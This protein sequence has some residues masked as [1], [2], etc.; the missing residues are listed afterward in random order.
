MK[1]TPYLNFS[2][3]GFGQDLAHASDKDQANLFNGISSEWKVAMGYE[4]G[5]MQMCYLS[6]YLSAEARK[7]IIKLCEFVKLREE[8][9]KELGR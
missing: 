5:D 2:I 9:S 8:E 4:S 3:E 7:W 6:N 1:I